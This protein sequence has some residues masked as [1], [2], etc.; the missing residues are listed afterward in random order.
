MTE[1]CHRNVF[2]Q[3]YQNLELVI[4]LNNDAFEE[5][6]VRESFSGFPLLQVLQVPE[7]SNLGVC[8]NAGASRATGSY[9]AKMDDDDVYG[10]SYIS[11]LML[12]ALESG[13]DIVGK[14]AAFY[15]FEDG[16]E[17]CLRHPQLRNRWLWP[18]TDETGRVECPAII[19]R[20]GSTAAGATLFVKS[21][22]IREFPFDESAPRGTDTLFQLACRRAGLTTYASDEFN[23]CYLRRADI[24]EHLW[25]I[26]K[27]GI[28]KSAVLLP[29]FD[30][31]QIFV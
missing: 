24:H 15:H 26:T 25:Q 17:H 27:L 18:W 9:V 10:P 8:I 31:S 20:N 12:S 3:N 2:C 13:A 21:S 16:Q 19:K 14:K 30:R 5:R 6:L 23:F 7:T 11:D 28:L 1:N 22:V 4:V 29:G